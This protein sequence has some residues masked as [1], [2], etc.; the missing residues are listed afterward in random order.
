MRFSLILSLN[1]NLHRD[2]TVESVHV[3]S[4]EAK[5]GIH[6]FCEDVLPKV[7]RIV[8]VN[9]HFSSTPMLSTLKAKIW[10]IKVH[11]HAHTIN[12]S[13]CGLTPRNLSTHRFYLGIGES[14]DV[15][16]WRKRGIK[17]PSTHEWA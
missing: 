13:S 8:A 12:G 10:C 15:R 16:L 7:A 17:Q 11:G 6:P 4:D 1:T 2:W 9:I 5:V 14:R 3:I